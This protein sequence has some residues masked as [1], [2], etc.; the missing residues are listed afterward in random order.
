VNFGDA[1]IYFTAYLLGGPIGAVAAAIGSALTDLTLGY[2]VYA[3]ATFIIKGLMGLTVG[4]MAKNNKF[5]AYTLSC[6]IAGAI[7]TVCY[8]LYETA[9][10][11]FA[12]AF[13]NAPGNLIQWGATFA[14]ALILFPV[15]KRIKKT[16]YIE[17]L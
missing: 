11:G 6:A 16:A 4:Y 13:T 7:M 10:F 2:I 5:W 15:A 9:V 3:P 12:V 17:R 1:F 8:A 14:A